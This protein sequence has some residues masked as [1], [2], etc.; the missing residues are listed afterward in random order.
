MASALALA[1]AMPFQ[2]FGFIEDRDMKTSEEME[3]SLGGYISA[4]SGN[5]SK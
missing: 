3:K 1:T 5:L 2:L 4:S